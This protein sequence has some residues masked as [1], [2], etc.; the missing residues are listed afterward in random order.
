MSILTSDEFPD[1]EGCAIRKRIQVL[2]RS[3]SIRD[4]KRAESKMDAN[5]GPPRI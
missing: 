3:D 5:I 2:Y 4:G 1:T